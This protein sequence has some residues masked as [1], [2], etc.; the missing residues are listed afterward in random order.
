MINHVSRKLGTSR[1]LNALTK[2]MKRCLQNH[3]Q[4]YSSILTCEL[5]NKIKL[6]PFNET[7]NWNQGGKI[8]KF[9]D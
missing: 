1:T 3:K 4:L 9:S 5:F 6:S 2:G 7:H 8:H